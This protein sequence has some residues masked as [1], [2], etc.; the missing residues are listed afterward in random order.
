MSS[1]KWFGF[2]YDAPAWEVMDEIKT[3]VGSSCLHCGEEIA[4]DDHGVTMPA[5]NADGTWFMASIH[6][7]CWLRQTIG[8]LAHINR[9]CGCFTGDFRKPESDPKLTYRE[10]AKMVFDR[11]WNRDAN[12]WSHNDT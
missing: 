1:M 7:E 11:W 6:V 2:Q 8:S 12:P 9:Q 5:G 3:P 4:A 10:E